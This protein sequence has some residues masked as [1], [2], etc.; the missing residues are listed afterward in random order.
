MGWIFCMSSAAHNDL[1]HLALMLLHSEG[2]HVLCR[3]LA[4]GAEVLATCCQT[5]QLTQGEGRLHY[6]FYHRRRNLITYFQDILL[7]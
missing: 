4:G 3:V 1:K 7:Q 5:N 2:K 6:S